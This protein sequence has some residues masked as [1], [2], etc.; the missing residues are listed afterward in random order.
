MLMS[1]GELT[2]LTSSGGWMVMSF[3]TLS[4]CTDV[5]T[6]SIQK[7]KCVSKSVHYNYAGFHHF[8]GKLSA[9]LSAIVDFSVSSPG[10]MTNIQTVFDLYP[11]GFGTCCQLL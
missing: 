11:L 10:C 4:Y 3:R 2:L 9:F 6:I 8:K 1:L 5:Q 7:E